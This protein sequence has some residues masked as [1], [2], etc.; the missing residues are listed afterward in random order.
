[1]SIGV[2]KISQRTLSE[3]Q[4]KARN[5]DLYLAAMQDVRQCRAVGT[6]EYRQGWTDC[7]RA[8]TAGIIEHDAEPPV[9]AYEDVPF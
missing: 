7:Y 3:L 6:Q 5:H 8:L 1:M 4:E 2:A 9:R